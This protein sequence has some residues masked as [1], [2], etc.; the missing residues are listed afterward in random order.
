MARSK[1][2]KAAVKAAEEEEKRLAAARDAA[3]LPIGN[4]VADGTPISDDEAN[5]VVA[6]RIGTPRLPKALPGG[7][8]E[9]LYN[10]VDLVLLLGI[11]D[12]EKGAEVAGSRGY[13]LK[14]EGVLLNQALINY[15]LAW[16]CRRGYS[17]VQTPFFMQKG[18]MAECAQLA[19]F[20]EE[21]Y[22]VRLWGCSLGARA[23]H[24]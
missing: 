9:K 19:Q 8:A 23:I 3:L 21:L 5:N 15:A 16:G 7:A 17:P 13:Y 11:A 2:L 12:L 1:T 6:R 22:K 14:N 10:H 20:D 18:V 24:C 4:L